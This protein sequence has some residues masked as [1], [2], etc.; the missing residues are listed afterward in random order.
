MGTG[1][2]AL[3]GLRES[4]S[5]SISRSHAYSAKKPSP[6]VLLLSHLAK[7]VETHSRFLFDQLL[8][9]QGHWQEV[10]NVIEG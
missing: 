2:L 9:H 8:N 1:A 4:V 5:D 10:T 7:H 3:R 6:I